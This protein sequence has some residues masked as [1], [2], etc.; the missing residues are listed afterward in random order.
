[1]MICFELIMHKIPNEKCSLRRGKKFSWNKTRK[2]MKKI[3]I[4]DI[5]INVEEVDLYSFIKSHKE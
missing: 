2:H 1:M 5:W 3:Y 4:N